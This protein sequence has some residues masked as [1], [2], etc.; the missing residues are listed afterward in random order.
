MIRADFSWNTGSAP[1]GHRERG[2][3]AILLLF[4]MS[5]FAVLGVAALTTGLGSAPEGRGGVET[6]SRETLTHFI[7]PLVVP[8]TWRA[9]GNQG[10]YEFQLPVVVPKRVAMRTARRPHRHELAEVEGMAVCCEGRAGRVLS[11]T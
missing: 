4:A 8:N 10:S 3:A 5:A 1:I 9:K 11:D 7:A 6:V 2:I